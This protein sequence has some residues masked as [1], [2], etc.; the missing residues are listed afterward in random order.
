VQVLVSLLE[1]SWASVQG[2]PVKLPAAG[3]LLSSTV[4][5]GND[6]VPVAA[7][8]T[9]AVQVVVASIGRVEGEHATDVEVD[10]NVTVTPKVPELIAW[11][12][13]PP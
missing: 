11:R 1:P 13:E 4:P 7:S 3:P 8:T 9:V 2:L 6:F 5:V 12:L 10:R